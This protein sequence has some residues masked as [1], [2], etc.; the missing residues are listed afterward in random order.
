MSSKLFPNKSEWFEWG[1]PEQYFQ[2]PFK[3]SKLE[4]ED[5]EWAQSLTPHQRIE[6]LLMIQEMLTKQFVENTP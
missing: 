6:W 5:L 3:I 1:T 4:W 2:I